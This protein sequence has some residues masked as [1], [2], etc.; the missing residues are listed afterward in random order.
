MRESEKGSIYQSIVA[1]G[2][3]SRQ[4]NDQIKVEL[5]SRMAD[6]VTT[7]DESEGANFDQ[8]SISR[9]FDRLPKPTFIA[10]KEISDDKL[11]YNLP[12]VEEEKEG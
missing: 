6:I 4:I 8:I 7:T 1:M 12:P 2:F 9:E 3:R 11:H 10:M 5:T